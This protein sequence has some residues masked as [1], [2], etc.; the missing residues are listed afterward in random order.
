MKYCISGFSQSDNKRVYMENPGVFYDEQ[1]GVRIAISKRH[2]DTFGYQANAHRQYH[3][4]HF[5]KDYLSEKVTIYIQYGE[6]VHCDWENPGSYIRGAAVYKLEVMMGSAILC[7]NPGPDSGEMLFAFPSTSVS[8][9][10]QN[11]IMKVLL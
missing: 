5:A 6:G 10:K 11:E 7:T 9:D 8:T 2:P 4:S 1:M 3:S